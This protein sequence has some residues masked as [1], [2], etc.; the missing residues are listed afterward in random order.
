MN[1]DQVFQQHALGLRI[2]ELREELKAEQAKRIQLEKALASST[3]HTQSGKIWMDF[4]RAVLEHIEGYTVPQYGDFPD[5]PVARFT[6]QDIKTQLLRYINRMESNA[7]GPAEA[8][9]DCLKIAHY[10]SILWMA[11]NPSTPQT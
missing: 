9:R 10:A 2:Q 5:C 4:H 1:R 7:R 3:P 8:K 11:L 6:V